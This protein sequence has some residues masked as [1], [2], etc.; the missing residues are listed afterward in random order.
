MA[1][2]EI[3]DLPIENFVAGMNQKD[4]FAPGSLL[5]TELDSESPLSYGLDK[6]IAV[7]NRRG[8]VF[9]P[10]ATVGNSPR[11]A[12]LYPD[13]DARLSGFLLGEKTPSGQRFD[14]CSGN[15]K[16]AGDFV[17]HGAAI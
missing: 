7:M 4:Y 12:G 9:L 11:M 5:L 13:Y 15:G 2:V 1:V 6:R 17:F 14:C 8:P 3:M 16:R 10:K